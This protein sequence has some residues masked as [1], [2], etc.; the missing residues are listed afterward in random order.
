[1]KLSPRNVLKGRVVDVILG[2]TAKPTGRSERDHK[3]ERSLLDLAQDRDRSPRQDRL[4]TSARHSGSGGR[5]ANRRPRS[6]TRR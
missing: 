5:V 4:Q 2:Q 3:V 1:M 6:I